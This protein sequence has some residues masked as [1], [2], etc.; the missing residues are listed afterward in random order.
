MTE[1]RIAFDSLAEDDQESV[2]A[3]N[4]EDLLAAEATLKP[5][6]GA[7]AAQ[8]ER[9]KEAVEEQDKT[10]GGKYTAG[11]FDAFL[12]IYEEAADALEHP[13]DEDAVERLTAGLKAAIDALLPILPGDMNGDGSLTITDVM[14]ACKVLA[15]KAAGKAPSDMEIHRGDLTGEGEVTITDV[16][17]TCKKLAQKD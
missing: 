7:L 3:V 11:S 14:A 6:T 17:E 10:P 12:P 5:D 16:M 15:R 1:A 2:M 4:Y 9:G 8:V 13:T